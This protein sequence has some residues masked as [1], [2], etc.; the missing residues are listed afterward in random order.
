MNIKGEIMKRYIF[1]IVLFGA[2]ISLIYMQFIRN[3]IEISGVF[4]SS[5]SHKCGPFYYR[6]NYCFTINRQYVWLLLESLKYQEKNGHIYKLFK[7]TPSMYGLD[8]DIYTYQKPQ[9]PFD[10]S[11]D[12]ILYLNGSMNWSSTGE[13]TLSHPCF[14]ENIKQITSDNWCIFSQPVQCNIGGGA[15]FIIGRIIY[16]KEEDNSITSHFVDEEQ[17]SKLTFLNLKNPLYLSL[18]AREFNEFNKSD[19]SQKRKK[20]I[21]KSVEKTKKH[22][23]YRNSM[24]LPIINLKKLVLKETEK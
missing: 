11:Y 2:L 12:R 9:P 4:N 20:H 3:P 17:F 23:G 15:I 14:L 18:F 7:F 8:I 6:S 24:P 16:L 22:K 21:L 1:G 19:T 5:Y 13:V 10:S